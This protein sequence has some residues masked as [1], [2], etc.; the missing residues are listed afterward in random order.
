METVQAGGFG[1][2]AKLRDV[3]I[4]RGWVL[5]RAGTLWEPLEAYFRGQKPY[6]EFAQ[7]GKSQSSLVSLV[8][9]C[10]HFGAVVEDP[11][12]STSQLIKFR[13]A[14]FWREQWQF[15]FLV[16]LAAR[17][18]NPKALREE[19][20]KTFDVAEHYCLPQIDREPITDDRGRH[21]W[22]SASAWQHLILDCQ[23]AI[24]APEPTERTSTGRQYTQAVLRCTRQHLAKMTEKALRTAAR[25]Y[26]ASAI[27]DCL[28]QLTP[29]L[30][31]DLEDRFRLY[32]HCEDLLQR[33][34]W[35]L[36]LD[37]DKRRLPSVC[38][39][40]GRF[41]DSSQGNV[42]YCP[43]RPECKDKGRRRLDW[44]RNKDKYNRTRREK[45]K[46]RKRKK[47]GRAVR[48]RQR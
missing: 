2:V 39:Y 21:Q 42:L 1:S 30:E 16:K 3:R 34:Y 41:F 11:Q 22:M 7:C 12:R 14:E 18:D 46:L 47:K 15:A 24:S 45:R 36:A 33:F 29:I 40:C 27:N 4:E 28:G 13:V 38:A 43:D 20:E 37:L 26:L 10:E 25:R 17:L 9:F 32:S 35:M 5:G 31:I 48:R 19:F 8:H 6:V 44:Q 23:R